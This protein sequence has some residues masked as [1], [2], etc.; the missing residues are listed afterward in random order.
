MKFKFE[1]A[2]GGMESTHIMWNPNYNDLFGV[3]L[4]EKLNSI[5]NFS[6]L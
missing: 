2:E 1:A 3:S 6:D 5:Y 4:G